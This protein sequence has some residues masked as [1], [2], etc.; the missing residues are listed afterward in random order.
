VRDSVAQYET[1]ADDVHD[2]KTIVCLFWIPPL[3]QVYRQ[4]PGF[5]RF[6]SSSLPPLNRQREGG[7]EIDWSTVPPSYAHPYVN[8]PTSINRN[9]FF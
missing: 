7:R 5:N 6:S 1:F 3:V 9:T 8:V 2:D 4:F